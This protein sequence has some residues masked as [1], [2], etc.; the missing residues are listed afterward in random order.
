MEI[1]GITDAS[2]QAMAANSSPKNEAS[3][4]MLRT[5]LD[6]QEQTATQLIESVPDPDSNVGHNIDEM[7]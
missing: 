6:I 5:A 3:T 7:V 4:K 2:V 1:S